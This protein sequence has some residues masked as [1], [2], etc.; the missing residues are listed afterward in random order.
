LGQTFSKPHVAIATE[1]HGDSK[2]LEMLAIGGNPV[3][4]PATLPDYNTGSCDGFCNSCTHALLP[5]LARFSFAH[6]PTNCYDPENSEMDRNHLA[7]S[8][9]RRICYNVFPPTPAL[10]G[11]VSRHQGF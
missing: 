3:S 5:A 9:R 4:T 10:R 11:T 1:P 6:Q 2:K 7:D 8:N